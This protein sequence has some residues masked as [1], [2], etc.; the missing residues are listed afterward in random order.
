MTLRLPDADALE[1]YLRQLDANRWYSNFGPLARSFAARLARHYAA[2]SRG[3]CLTA[4]ATLGLT[5]ALQEAAARKPNGFCIVPSWTFAASAHAIR[6]SGLRPLFVD[7][8]AATGQLTPAIASAA[9]GEEVAAV[10]AVSAFGQPVDPR[11]WEA[12]RAATQLEVVIDGA[13]AFDSATTSTLPTVVSLHATKPLPCGEG[14]FVLCADEGLIERLRRRT[15]FGFDP[16]RR[17]EFA[18]LNAKMSEYHAAVAHA[19][20]DR[21]PLSRERLM[22]VGRFYRERLNAIPAVWLAPGWA[23]SWISTTLNVRIAAP[24]D[25]VPLR[26]A[27]QALGVEA[28]SWWGPGCHAQAAFSTCARTPL[29]V[30]ETIAGSTLGLPFSAEFSQADVAEIVARLERALESAGRTQR[31]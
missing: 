22:T 31:A 10:L 13:G 7:V 16:E 23:E 30:T 11:P 18:G 8:D 24:V 2:P 15:N 1:P 20:L 26:A 12:F 3:V 9:A 28:R 19:S 5:V 14:G 25:V 6:S 17:A 4:N 29:P 21:W 27:L